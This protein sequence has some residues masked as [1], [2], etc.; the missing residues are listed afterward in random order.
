VQRRHEY[1]LNVKGK[2]HPGSYGK[3]KGDNEI[4]PS[5]YAKIRGGYGRP[6]TQGE[7]VD[8]FDYLLRRMIQV[9][10]IPDAPD[11]SHGMGAAGAIGA[12]GDDEE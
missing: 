5:E 1:F 10:Q 6:I 9:E 8:P 12:G 3:E 11:E 4:I 2:V 7:R